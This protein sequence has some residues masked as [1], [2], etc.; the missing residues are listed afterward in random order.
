MMERLETPFRL[1]L[2][3]DVPA[4]FAVFLSEGKP[5]LGRTTRLRRRLQRLLDN[6]ATSRRRLSLVGLARAIEIYPSGSRLDA[7]LTFHALAK[8][9]YPDEY[10]RID[11]LRLP[12]YVKV[13]LANPFPRTQVTTKISASA[14]LHYGPFRSRAQAER[15]ESDV[16]DLFQVRRCQEDLAVSPDHPGCIYGEMARCLRP[17][18]EVVT[19]DEYMS[20]VRRMTHFFETEGES[21]LG[22]IR[23]ARDRASDEL[24]F[25]NAQRQH[26]RAQRI[27][28]V[29]KLRDDLATDIRKLCGVAVTRSCE[30][31][32]VELR[33][34]LAGQWLP[35]VNFRVAPDA[36]GEMIPLDRRVREVVAAL[37]PPVMNA[38]ACTEDMA[39]LARWYYSSWRDGEWTP[40]ASID[41][42]PYRRLIRAISKIAS[43]TGGSGV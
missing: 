18:Q 23:A 8:Q 43:E 25:E 32:F 31:G 1:D 17:C 6:P 2:L 38:R 27:E 15:F 3:P 35:P 16:L 36:S 33:F 42:L 11:K 40:F 34:L 24:D 41:N 13:L 14:A 39:L 5:Y 10:T 26:Q 21:L 29:L 30:A 12:P 28:Q 9:Y 20:E 37:K 19:A 7:S 4:V 22:P